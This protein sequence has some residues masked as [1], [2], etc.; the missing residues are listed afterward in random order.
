[1]PHSRPDFESR[2]P[3]LALPS[4]LHPSVS[5]DSSRFVP[6][7]IAWIDRTDL[8]TPRMPTL[9]RLR[10]AVSDVTYGGMSPIEHDPCRRRPM[11]LH[12]SVRAANRSRRWMHDSGGSWPQRIIRGG[13]CPPRSTTR[14]TYARLASRVQARSSGYSAFILVRRPQGADRYITWRMGLYLRSRR[15]VRV[16]RRWKAE[17]LLLQVPPGPLLGAP[18]DVSLPAPPGPKRHVIPRT[19]SSGSLLHDPFVHPGL[20][21][22]T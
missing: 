6:Q 15:V 12:V 18:G 17:K 3:P 5:S 21:Q 14:R 16:P 22:D 2:S 19:Y 13:D 11:I 1:M 7:T 10:V 9:I 8:A 4:S 20:D